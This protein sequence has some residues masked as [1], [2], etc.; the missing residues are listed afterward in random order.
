M[1][2]GPNIEDADE[3]ANGR[4]WECC[5]SELEGFIFDFVRALAYV[6]RRVEDILWL[7]GHQ[8]NKGGKKVAEGEAIKQLV[9]G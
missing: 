3:L 5:D 9:G 6:E 8:Q 2:V 1:V 4:W 7:S